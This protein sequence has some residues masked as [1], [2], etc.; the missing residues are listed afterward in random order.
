ML[1]LALEIGPLAVFFLANLHGEELM[2][3]Q[4]WF[5]DSADSAIIFATAAL[6]VA[7]CLSLVISWLVLRRIPVMPLV[8]GV[9]IL[10]FGALTLWLRDETFIK[11]KPTIVNY[12]FAATLFGS[13]WLRRPILQL[14]LDGALRL[15]DDGWRVLTW[16]WAFFFLAIGT[17]NE[18]I[19]RNFSTD[20]WVSFKVFG[21][22]PLTIVFSLLQIPLI[23]RH[24][25]GEPQR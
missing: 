10:I 23:M 19:W 9:L 8:G 22:M 14:L 7:I 18:I 17:L 24:M 2:A 11:L 12:M 1:K 25:A 16:R 4:G 20:F 5:Q 6:M 13:L 3:R 21:M 15:D